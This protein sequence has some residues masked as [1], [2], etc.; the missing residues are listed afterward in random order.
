MINTANRSSTHMKTKTHKHNTKLAKIEFVENHVKMENFLF[1][2]MRES[3]RAVR[4]SLEMK[5]S[6]NSEQIYIL[7]H[8]DWTKIEKK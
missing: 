2:R 4:K 3:A 1:L 8:S 7:N 5:N 6:I